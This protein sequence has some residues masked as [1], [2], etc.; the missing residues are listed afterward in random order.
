MN[1]KKIIR[2][3]NLDIVSFNCPSEDVLTRRKSALLKLKKEIGNDSLD[4]T[5]E[6]CQDIPFSEYY[7]VPFCFSN[8]MSKTVPYNIFSS[9]NYFDAFS[10][11]GV[12]VFDESIYK[13]C[14]LNAAQQISKDGF[15]LNEFHPI[16]KE[17][18]S[19]LK[20]VSKK[21]TIS[22]HMSGTEAVMHAIRL[23]KFNTG[24]KNVVKFKDAYHGWCLPESVIEIKE[25]KDLLKI[26]DCAAIL[27]NPLS[28]L[29]T[30]QTQKTDAILFAG[31][32]SEDYNK[33][34]EIQK[35]KE[36][37]EICN[38]K[39][40]VFILDEVFLGFRVAFGGC[41]EFFEIDADIVTYG[42]TIA[43]GFPIGIVCGKEK[44]S[45]RYD[46]NHPL[47]FLGNKGTFSAHPMGMLSMNNFI[48]SI[49]S[50]D[51]SG[52]ESLWN[53]RIRS[54]NKEIKEYGIE[55]KNL[56]SVI[57]PKKLPLSSHNWLIQFYMQKNGIKL[58]PYG[59]SRFIFKIN[60]TE[61]EWDIFRVK[62][63]SSL[64]EMRDDGWFEVKHSKKWKL[65]L[66]YV[67]KYLTK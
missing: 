55:F 65:Y 14:L 38:K 18:I 46:E 36:I 3:K 28:G 39:G 2:L 12:K 40:I 42:K 50:E 26:D 5:R 51:Y 54:L 49:K 61:E 9:K 44:H 57:C 10:S 62:I 23:A 60:L 1:L 16:V 59:F 47:L 22:F 66:E 6:S 34:K 15:Y 43:G 17:N 33:Q 63:I 7:R 4:T 56:H 32:D 25:P 19:F 21:D 31:C 64:S 45:K 27:V 37:R 13:N 67:K 8:E 53:N 52:T 30:K 41:Q 35:Y 29:Y 58:G 48:N 20:K 24:R 11:Y